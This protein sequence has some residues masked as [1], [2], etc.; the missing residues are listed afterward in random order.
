MDVPVLMDN[1]EKSPE[2]IRE[3]DGPSVPRVGS[4]SITLLCKARCII[5]IRYIIRLIE[6]IEIPGASKQGLKTK[7]S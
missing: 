5:A 6:T 2:H 1:S 7:I 3:I 4:K